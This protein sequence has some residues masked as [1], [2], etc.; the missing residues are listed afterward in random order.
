MSKLEVADKANETIQAKWTI[1][2]K[3]FADGTYTDSESKTLD[4]KIDL[5]SNMYCH[6]SRYGV[7]DFEVTGNIGAKEKYYIH[8]EQIGEDTLYSD[9]MRYFSSGQF[10]ISVDGIF[11]PDKKS[12]ILDVSN[13]GLKLQ[14]DDKTDFEFIVSG[15]SVKVHKLLL[16]AES[17]VF[18]DMFE[19]AT[20]DKV[21]ITGFKLETFKAAV[22]FCY[23]QD[24]ADFVTNDENAVELL[25]FADKHDFKTLK[26][27]LE[28]HFRNLLT[29]KN[30]GIMVAAANKVK[31]QSLRQ[32][33][34]DF[35]R[36]LLNNN[37]SGSNI[38]ISFF[39]AKFLQEVL[40]QA[41]KP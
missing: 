41:L 17:S 31:C 33:C 2:K 15:E 25:L 40:Q 18:N 32:A 19:N 3:T 11:K 38:D 21:E 6:K 27:K 10:C 37:K 14:K 34:I 1:E 23:A 8:L 30:V 12:I 7:F 4:E 22:D 26:P 39:D 36:S 5:T 29:T 20:G 24:I 16:S 28:A 35:V 9:S 13:W